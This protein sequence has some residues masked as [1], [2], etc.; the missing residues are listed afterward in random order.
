M[1]YE[2]RGDNMPVVVC[3]LES[4]E[5]MITEGGSMA[6][7]SPNMEMTTSGG[8]SFGA[9]MGRLFSGERIFQNIYTARGGE[10]MISFVPSFPGTILALDVTPDKPLI[11]QKRAFLASESGVKLSTY[12]Q[13]KGMAGFFGGEGFIMQ[14]VSGKGKVFI[15]VDGS[16][17]SY[18]LGAAEQLV[19]DTGT[20]AAMDAS[21]TMDVV[22]VKGAKNVLFGGEGLFNTVVTGPG[23]VTLQTISF[24]NLVNTIAASIPSKS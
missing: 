6:W 20:L 13:K 11:L 5:S 12:F 14:K 15:E 23:K 8:G 4:G 2:I 17:V 3:E 19:I 9:A 18:E 16:A 21:C 10:G 22:T 1:K 7:M 24:T